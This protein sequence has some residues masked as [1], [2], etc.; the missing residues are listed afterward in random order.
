M[1]LDKLTGA[2]SS[3]PSLA[4]PTGASSTD[5]KVLAPA[6]N[7]LIEEVNALGLKVAALTPAPLPPVTPDLPVVLIDAAGYAL[8][9]GLPIGASFV[10]KGPLGTG[11]FL[12][13]KQP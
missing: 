11:S 13:Q 5:Q 7:R 9:N 8:I 1:A 12:S 2:I 3:T 6:I 10:L 4:V